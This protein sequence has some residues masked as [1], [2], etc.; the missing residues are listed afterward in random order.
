M[1]HRSF[2]RNL[3][4]RALTACVAFSVA[5]LLP[6]ASAQ[7]GTLS[8][9]AALTSDYVFRG[10]TQTLGDPA[11]QFGLRW[12]SEPGVYAAVW[13]SMVEFP[14]DTGASSELDYVLGWSGNLDDA[15]ALD[16]GVTHF[17][18][19]SARADLRYA[20]F[21]ATLTYAG[22]YWLTLGYSPDVFATDET[23][24]YA[25]IGAKFPL[26]DAWRLEAAAGCYQLD[27][28]YGDNYAHAQLGLVWAA[29]APV[30]LRLTAHATDSSAKTLFPGLAG[31]RLEAA[32]SAAF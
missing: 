26:G 6:L 10:I 28:A 2:F 21:I 16:A 11:A 8:G 31:S 27:D 29:R 19:P 14:G 9:S 7:A 30:E 32:V 4:R 22:N 12:Q 25:Q 13:G 20:E 23:G 18:Y 24:I 5:G 15:W 3:P 17:D 1:R